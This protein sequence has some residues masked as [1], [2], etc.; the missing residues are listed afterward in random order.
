MTRQIQTNF[1]QAN[2]RTSL[3]SSVVQRDCVR[4]SPPVSPMV[5]VNFDC[6]VLKDLG[7]IGIGVMVHD[8]QGLVLASMSEKI[9]L[10]QSVTDVKALVAMRAVNFA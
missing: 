9:L 6:V 1:L 7:E 10:S 2:P 3:T 4:W 8:F 5:K